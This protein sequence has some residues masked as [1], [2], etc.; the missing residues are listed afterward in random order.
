MRSRSESEQAD[1]LF[2]AI[3]QWFLLALAIAGFVV[4]GSFIVSVWLTKL[5]FNLINQLTDGALDKN[6][7][8]ALLISAVV[9]GGVALGFTPYVTQQGVPLEQ[10]IGGLLVAGMGWGLAVGYKALLDWWRELEMRELPAT[11][12]SQKLNLPE[13]HYLSAE[14]ASGVSPR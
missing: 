2:W 1:E 12:F 14:T 4:S 11:H 5:L 9:F 6:E 10:A 13:Q 7:G 8:L 3:V